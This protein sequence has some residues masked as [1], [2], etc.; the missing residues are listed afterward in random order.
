MELRFKAVSVKAPH[1]APFDSP[2]KLKVWCIYTRENPESV[3]EGESPV[4][5]RLLTSHEVSDVTQTLTCIQ[6]VV[7]KAVLPSLEL[8]SER[9]T[10]GRNPYPANT[11]LWAAWIVAKLGG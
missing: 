2:R 1:T 7:M 9:Y 8:K 11:L 6:L 3:P 10:K 4:E 5:W